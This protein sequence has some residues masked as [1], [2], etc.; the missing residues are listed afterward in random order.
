MSLNTPTERA[1]HAAAVGPPWLACGEISPNGM[2]VRDRR[3][4]L[5]WMSDSES[6][7]PNLLLLVPQF[8][9]YNAAHYIAN[10]IY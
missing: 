4:L 2:T 8:W 1:S 3:M 5:L 6:A 7:C 10:E 9:Q